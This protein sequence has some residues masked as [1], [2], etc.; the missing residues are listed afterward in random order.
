MSLDIFIGIA[1]WPWNA[2]QQQIN[3]VEHQ[4]SIM[5]LGRWINLWPAPQMGELMVSW[6][7]KKQQV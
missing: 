1:S 3:S 4:G 6:N 2:I 7:N 5:A